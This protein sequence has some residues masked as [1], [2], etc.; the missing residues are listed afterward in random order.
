PSMTEVCANHRPRVDPQDEPKVLAMQLG[1]DPATVASIEAGGKAG[2]AAPGS[3]IYVNDPTAYEWAVRAGYPLTVLV[4]VMLDMF[5]H[6]QQHGVHI[7]KAMMRAG[8]ADIS[9]RIARHLANDPAMR[10]F[11]ATDH[12]FTD[13]RMGTKLPVP[14]EIL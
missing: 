14:P 7:H 5:T 4:Y 2:W 8:F 11:V 10:L 13:T 12:G 6:P 9:K 1:I 3:F